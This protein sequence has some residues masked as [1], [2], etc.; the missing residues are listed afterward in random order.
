MRILFVCTG[1][2]CRSPMAERLAASWAREALDGSPESHELQI[3]SA[4]LLATPDLPMDRR[5][6]AALVALG[7]D[8]VAFASRIYT[9]D[10]GERADLVLTMTRRHRRAVLESTPRGL[11]RTF[12]LREAADLLQNADLT[13]LSLQSLP[14]RVGELADRLH[15]ARAWRASTDMDDV[16]DPIGRRPAVHEEVAGVIATSLRPLTDVLFTSVRARLPS[17]SMV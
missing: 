8:P 13:G 10:M 4:G 12:T 14:A 7:G 16:A 15:A 1:N 6:A 3:D 17:P 5:A 9:P 11:R 2:I